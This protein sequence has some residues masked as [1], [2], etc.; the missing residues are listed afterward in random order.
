LQWLTAKSLLRI[1]TINNLID[2]GAERGLLSG[3]CQY[4]KD[5]YLDSKDIVR[6]LDFNHI[7]G[8]IYAAL[9]KAFQKNIDVQ[10]DLPT[11]LSNAKDLGLLQEIQNEVKYIKSLFELFV[12][13]SNVRDFARKIRK[14][15]ETRDLIGKFSET[16]QKLNNISGDETISEIAAI[17]EGP[18]FEFTNKLITGDKQ[19]KQVGEGVDEFIDDIIANKDTG[20]LKGI[21]I[22]CPKY[23]QAI[24]GLINGVHVI[25][26]RKKCGKSMWAINAALR[27]AAFSKVPVLFLDTELNLKYGQWVRMLT[28][29]SQNTEHDEIK[30]GIFAD[31]NIKLNDVERASRILQTLPMDY[32]NIT[33]KN[34][35]EI[36]SVIRRWLIQKVGYNLEGN[37]NKCLVVYDYLKPPR[38]GKDL[39]AA[40]KEYQEMGYRVGFLHEITTEYNF[41]ILTFVQLNKEYDAA[42]SDRIGWYCSSYSSFHKKTEEEIAEDTAAKGNRKLLPE[43]CRFG[44]GLEMGDYINYS[45]NGKR[46]KVIEL[47]S[48]NELQR[49]RRAAEQCAD[50]G[51]D[52]N[53]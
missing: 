6:Q 16:V 11:I 41:P 45:L 19:V 40:V 5:A 21:S 12:E 33:G 20:L 32:L 53:Q 38:D 4:G 15:T 7:N 30:Y 23:E 13:K 48:R 10:V 1:R 8:I 36:I 44:E 17:A 28:C 51:E 25:G 2:I 52:D 37:L 26:A 24:G 47:D 27:A 46:A 29:L 50:D 49:Q 3:I 39:S 22:K 9:D 14:L 43:D 42:V 34:I 31:N 18:I 35:E